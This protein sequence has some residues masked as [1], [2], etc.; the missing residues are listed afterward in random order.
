MDFMGVGVV[1]PYFVYF[2]FFHGC[3]CDF[4]FNEQ[5]QT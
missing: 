5:V 4:N 1:A 2:D 3:G